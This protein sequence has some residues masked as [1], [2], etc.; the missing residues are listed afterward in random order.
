MKKPCSGGEKIRGD[1][2]HYEFLLSP[3]LLSKNK[4]EEDATKLYS[5]TSRRF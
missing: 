5:G 2:N 1:S 3:F 4:D